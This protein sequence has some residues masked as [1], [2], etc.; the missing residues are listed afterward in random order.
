MQKAPDDWEFFCDDD[1]NIRYN[2]LCAECTLLC[3]QS[4]RVSIESCPY[5]EIN[6][7]RIDLYDDD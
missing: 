3:K 6:I 7:K 2:N 4:F 1:G 5:S